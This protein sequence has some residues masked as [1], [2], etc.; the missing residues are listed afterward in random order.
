[1][2]SS[3]CFFWSV[4]KDSFL[5]V[6]VVPIVDVVDDDVVDDGV[7]VDGIISSTRLVLLLFLLLSVD[8]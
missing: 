1:M 5:V 3:R 2:I 4:V 6:V 7:V 8:I